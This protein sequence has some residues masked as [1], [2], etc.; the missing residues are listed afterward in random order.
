MFLKIKCLGFR[1]IEKTYRVI[2]RSNNLFVN[3][4]Y[5]YN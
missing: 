2:V 3:Q 1:L 4:F 5:Y